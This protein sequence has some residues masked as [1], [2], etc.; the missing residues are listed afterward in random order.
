MRQF[1]R[2]I[3]LN[4]TKI[5]DPPDRPSIPESTTLLWKLAFP[6]LLRPSS[7][8]QVWKHDRPEG[9]AFAPIATARSEY[10]TMGMVNE[11]KPYQWC[12]RLVC[13]E[14][15]TFRMVWWLAV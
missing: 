8:L 3:R 1:K 7:H 12:A 15:P 6:D 14:K 2:K 5:A 10:A 11:G 13:E 4:R 9:L